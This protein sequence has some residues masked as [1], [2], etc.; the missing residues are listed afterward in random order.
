MANFNRPANSLARITSPAVMLAVSLAAA[1]GLA[2]LPSSISRT[3][4]SGWREA[5]LPGVRAAE[6]V[7][8][9]AGAVFDKLRPTDT[10]ENAR[11][12]EEVA[13]LT[14]QVNRLQTQLLI[15]ASSPATGDWATASDKKPPLLITQ[16]IPARVLGSQAIMYLSAHEL[17]DVGKTKGAA[18]GAFVVDSSNPAGQTATDK[19][20]LDEGS[21]AAVQ[22][23]HLVLAGSRVWGRIIEVGPHTSTVRRITDSG[24]RELVQLAAKRDG[25]LQ[26]TARGLLVG[27]GG[28]QCKIDLVDAGE[29]V[30]AG[31]LVITADDGV[32]DVPLQY[33]TVARVEHKPGD[34]HLQIW[35]E[36]ALDP[37]R[38]P[39][40]VA[41][42]TLDI[43]PARV[44][45][46]EPR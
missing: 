46:N 35:I 32:L 27:T 14:D 20:Y 18:P 5:L 39:S 7:S 25:H 8:S 11:A 9:I 12:H 6:S 36:P 22:P 24:Y 44:G 33:G 4:R 29:L 13:Q 30:S 26:F 1:I 41:I 43:N 40:R 45:L 31:D 3:L 21:D 10:V 17:L 38:P 42:L 34:P 2:V 23:R 28:R 15:A 19:T 16:V 37:S